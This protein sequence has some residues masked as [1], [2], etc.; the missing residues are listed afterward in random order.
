MREA[1][2]IFLRAKYIGIVIAL[3]VANVLMFQ[4]SQME[5]MS[6]LSDP[7]TH[8]GI[9][10]EWEIER[11]QKRQDF[12]ERIENIDEQRESMLSISI[13]SDENSFSYKNINR[14]QEDFEVLK[15]VKIDNVND[16]AIKAFLEHDEMYIIGFLIVLF[17]VMAFFDERKSGLWQ[18]IYG[19]KRGRFNLVL[20]RIII[21][22]L[23]ALVTGTILI[24]STLSVSFYDYGGTDILGASVQS[25]TM[26]QN[27]ILTV[28]VSEFLIYFAI[29]YSAAIFVSGAF[30]WGILS[31]IHNRNTG[32]IVCVVVYGIECFIYNIL[33][34]TNPLCILKYTNMYFLLNPKEIFTE[35]QN[36]AL[37]HMLLNTRTYVTML[38]A[39]LVC[40]TTVWV[41]IANVHTRPLYIPGIFEKVFE[42]MMNRLRRVMCRFNGM[43][44]EL[45]K[46]LVQGKGIVILGIFI[47]IMVSNINAGEILLSPGRELL[48]DFYT[49][50]TCEIDDELIEL[51]EEMEVDVKESEKELKITLD[52]E[53]HM[54]EELS[55]QIERA[56]RL[57][58]KGISG[59]FINDRGF[60]RIIGSKGMVKRLIGGIFGALTLIL[61]IAPVYSFE[62]QSE[63][64]NIIQCTK[65]GRNKLFARKFGYALLCTVMVS[66]VIFVTELI[67]VMA[68]YSLKGLMAPVQNIGMLEDFPIDMSIGGL[69]VIWYLIRM[70]T[71]A[72]IS[73][74]AMYISTLNTRT[75]RS[76]LVCMILLP[77]GLLSGVS[78]Y[79]LVNVSIVRILVIAVV[80]MACIVTG[81]ILT[82]KKWTNKSL[83][84]E[85]V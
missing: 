34:P 53:R 16:I 8:D 9:I 15:Q 60:E 33:L 47:Y 35:Y 58:S 67:E 61:L 44:Y 41:I 29:I 66:V 18:I 20:K 3:L 46:C 70:L 74:T 25:V 13:F 76:Y 43:G 85:R 2:R 6:L 7:E 78:E 84:R 57:S 75:D 40:I 45:Y 64:V 79:T 19:C 59:W 72:V 31:T 28:S 49:E 63:M 17:T 80:Y 5:S 48:N 14:T 12:Y 24:T 83:R 55:I 82:Y 1:R 77:V 71:L 21:L 23:V 27:L 32:M 38:I 11:E 30:V 51:Y 52:S 73:C 36:F 56:E 39:V 68:N 65:R 37:A 26:L 54:L 4:Y 10:A 50:H 42:K 22:A 69:L 62:K 81:L